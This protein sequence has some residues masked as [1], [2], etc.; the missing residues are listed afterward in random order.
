VCAAP[1]LSNRT[2]TVSVTT[3]VPTNSRLLIANAVV[4]TM[5]TMQEEEILPNHCIRI[6]CVARMGARG[7][8]VSVLTAT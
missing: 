5:R 2:L 8:I 1:F 6:L 3:P 7:N 4:V